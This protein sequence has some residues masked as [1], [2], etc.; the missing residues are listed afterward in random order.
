MLPQNTHSATAISPEDL[1]DVGV[2]SIAL[3]QAAWPTLSAGLSLV[4]EF[5]TCFFN[6]QCAQRVEAFF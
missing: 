6:A 5:S 1:I 4:A 3:A 2:A